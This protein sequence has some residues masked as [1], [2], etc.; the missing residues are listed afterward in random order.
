MTCIVG[1]I[2]KNRVTVGGDSAGARGSHITIRADEKVFT[3]GEMIFGFTSSFRMGQ[4]IRY[5]LK[6]PEQS[7]KMEDYEYMCS[8]FTD[9]LIKCLQDKGFATVDDN[10]VKGG[11]FLVGYKGALY[12]IES[13][14]QVGKSAKNYDACGCGERYALGALAATKYLKLEPTERIKRALEVATEF[15]S[16]VRPPFVI[17][18]I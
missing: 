17:K 8:V 4:L 3:K 6:I 16:G 13:D 11:E 7:Q 1:W 15:S 14:F 18:E 10:V 9:A 5:V 12:H 2:E